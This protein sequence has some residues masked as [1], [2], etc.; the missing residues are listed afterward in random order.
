MI[1]ILV[2]D[3]SQVMRN[4]VRNSFAEMKVPFQSFEAENGKQALELLSSKNISLVFLDWNMP[5]MDGMDFLK[6]VRALPAYKKLPIVMVTSERGRFSVVQALKSG[7]TD[8]IVK[9]VQEKVFKEK[10]REILVTIR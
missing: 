7:A 5:G 4:I 8:Y 2:V 6:V 10:V 1:N 3:D 9:P